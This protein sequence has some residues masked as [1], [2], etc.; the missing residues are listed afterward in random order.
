MA[1]AELYLKERQRKYP[2]NDLIYQHKNIFS[3]LIDIF[4]MNTYKKA[5]SSQNRTAPVP[6]STRFD[7][8]RNGTHSYPCGGKHD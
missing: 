1:I 6:K 8:D 3:N 4:T 7:P 2:A 5:T